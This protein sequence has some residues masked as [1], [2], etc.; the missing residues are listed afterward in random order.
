MARDDE[1]L[2]STRDLGALLHGLEEALAKEVE[3]YDANRLLNTPIDD[4]C[5]YF[6]ERQ[7]IDPL[8]LADDSR[9]T[10][11]TGE[12][13]IDTRRMPGGRFNYGDHQPTI[14][15][16]SFSFFVPFTGAA[17][18]FQY[19][20]STYTHSP[21]RATING[22]SLVLTFT[23]PVNETGGIKP[24]FSNQL[25]QVRSYVGFI[26]LAVDDLN[27]NRLPRAAR[28]AIEE[29]KT[30]LLQAQNVA[31]SLGSPMRQRAGMPATYAAPTVRRKIM[32]PQP[33]GSNTPFKPEP[34]LPSETYEHILTVMQNM[35]LVLERSPSAF[36]AMGEEDLRQ[37][38]LVQLNGHYEGAATGETFNVE[39][40]TDILVRDGGKNIFIA[41]CKFWSGPKG[42]QEAIDQLLGYTSWR[43]TKTAVVLFNRG[44]AFSTVLGKVP[45]CL[46]AHPKFKRMEKQEGDTRFRAVLSHKNDPER[47]LIVTVLAFD[48]PQ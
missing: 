30:R 45:E 18:L 13:T 7:R 11:E 43:D 12:A 3:S 35:A 48:V 34:T 28:R 23:V 26:K 6:V 9:I 37:H 20:P 47:E 21:P 5:S 29:R 38:F 36:T 40:K 4:L 39:G 19:R 10:V 8:S 25:N 32:P 14:P 27:N 1:S 31:A 44:T 15:A 24:E 16:T 22:S 41:E 42:F 33:I 17:D 2:F 46:R